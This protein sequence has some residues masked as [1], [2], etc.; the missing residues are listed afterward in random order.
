MHEDAIELTGLAAVHE[1]PQTAVDS[2]DSDSDDDDSSRALLAAHGRPLACA[3]RVWPQV[4]GIVTEVRRDPAA[5]RETDLPQSAPTLLFTTVGLLLT[6]KFLDQVSVSAS[7]SS[8]QPPTAVVQHWHAMTEVHQLIMIIPVL[9]NL[10]GN[11]EMNLSARLC[12]A[13]NIGQLDDPAIRRAMVTGNLALLQVQAAVVSFI[14]AWIAYLLGVLLPRGPPP[15]PADNFVEKPVRPLL[16]AAPAHP[17]PD[18][19][20]SPPPA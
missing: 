1:K 17:S 6:G 9:L 16:P 4:R 8:L 14:A 7:V 10:K 15:A 19:Q 18:S 3:A 12:T 13:A 5:R 20:W 2:D 11:L